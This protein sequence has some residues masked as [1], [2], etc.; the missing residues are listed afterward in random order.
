MP[1][2]LIS[3]G[4]VL[5]QLTMNIHISHTGREIAVVKFRDSTNFGTFLYTEVHLLLPRVF[6]IFDGV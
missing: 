5:V 3:V 1:R 6:L 4:C 2:H